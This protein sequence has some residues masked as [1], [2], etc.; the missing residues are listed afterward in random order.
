MHHKSAFGLLVFLFFTCSVFAQTPTYR[1]LSNAADSIYKL[2]NYAL[3][4]ETYSKALVANGYKAFVHD[5]YR[6]AC[7][8]GQIGKADSA[9]YQL[10]YLANRPHFHE[11]TPEGLTKDADLNPLKTDARWPEFYSIIKKQKDEAE[12]N[13]DLPLVTVLDEVY[14]EDQKY[15]QQIDSIEK[16]FG[17][18]SP[19]MQAHWLIIRE[20]DSINE[21]KVCKIL[22]ERGWLGADIVG[23]KGASALFLVIQHADI[24]IQEKY[25]PMM[26]EAV[27]N[28]KAEGS[29]LAL[30]EDRVA[31]RQGKK[32]I[33]GS[34]ISRTPTGEHFVQALD[35]PDNVDTR[36]AS[37]GL[38]PLA[39]YV[40]NWKIIWNVEAYKKR[41]PEFEKLLQKN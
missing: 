30:L 40:S 23:R 25:L 4:A 12:K 14:T 37:V 1:D 27:K 8:L 2:K 39:Q 5:R 28:K 21:I 33:Y 3:A 9:F 35:D 38:P 29:S 41:L 18:K 26:R 22:D 34:Q 10:F 17:F 15:R 24:K 36:R 13:Y 11:F 19:E 32:Q 6:Y 20:K 31:L 7:A 16:K